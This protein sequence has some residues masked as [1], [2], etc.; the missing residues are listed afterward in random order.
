MF[1][2]II[3]YSGT[4]HLVCEFLDHREV[5]NLALVSKSVSTTASTA[6]LNLVGVESCIFN[7]WV[8]PHKGKF[9]RKLTP[10]PKGEPSTSVLLT[11]LKETHGIEQ[12][13]NVKDPSRITKIDKCRYPRISNCHEINKT[14]F[15]LVCQMPNLVAVDIEGDMLRCVLSALAKSG[16]KLESLTVYNDIVCPIDDAY[17]HMHNNKRV[18][19]LS[20]LRFLDIGFSGIEILAQRECQA[21][22][23][24]TLVVWK[25]GNKASPA[26]SLCKGGGEG[27]LFG[28]CKRLSWLELYFVEPDDEISRFLLSRRLQLTH[29]S[30]LYNYRSNVIWNSPVLS[31]CKWQVTG[32]LSLC[33]MSNLED[34]WR[35]VDF[36]G[37]HTLEKK[38]HYTLLAER[39]LPNGL[40]PLKNLKHLRSSDSFANMAPFL[41]EV[42]SLVSLRV[43]PGEFLTK[44]HPQPN[45]TSL[46]IAFEG[47][48]S[49]P[50][51]ILPNL[52]GLTP[53]M[54]SCDDA[55]VPDDWSK[56]SLSR[57]KTLGFPSLGY[58][59]EQEWLHSIID[60][61]PSAT[62]LV[63]GLCFDS[64]DP[65]ES[66][67]L[68][69]LVEALNSSEGNRQ[70]DC[71]TFG[72]CNGPVDGECIVDYLPKL[73][74][75]TRQVKVYIQAEVP[76]LDDFLSC[77]NIKRRR[78]HVSITP[79]L[80]G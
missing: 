49:I 37:I 77:Y 15:Y 29:L 79:S 36:S 59:G 56:N 31:G 57:V 48:D 63:V 30:A 11:R 43:P 25:L 28:S 6:P 24:E 72:N 18:P 46:E 41:K 19:D 60:A 4:G 5:A 69:S 16:A 47:N 40:P 3:G 17:M 76:K 71:I 38:P 73:M 52:E 14:L 26:S 67:N 53:Y 33:G 44:L 9:I 51:H 1:Q 45:C 65:P 21:H 10:F 75:F 64:Y 70:W 34:V 35:H 32:S 12:L 66:F 50:W 39:K 80:T 8:P 74:E 22:N 27:S 13:L 55:W 62:K 23:I 54:G 78:N 58:G 61:S 2:N 7:K 42:T 20:S 68:E